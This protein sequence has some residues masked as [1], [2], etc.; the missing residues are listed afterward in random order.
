MNPEPDEA[1][2]RRILSGER[3]AFGK[4]YDRY[5]DSVYRYCLRLVADDATAQ[6]AMQNTFVKALESIATLDSPRAFRFWLFRIARNEVYAHF[7]RVKSN[8][9]VPIDQHAEEVWD[10]PTPLELTSSKELVLLVQWA[11]E[12]LKVEYREVLVL[13]E[14][15]QL[16]YQEIAAVMGDSESS[17]KSRIFK[18]RKALTTIL[19]PYMK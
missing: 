19:E 3:Q 9:Q 16:S 6:D 8:G 12:R 17:V 18:A 4:L 5:K 11:M 1:A 2:I 7:R 13:R 15:E 14:Y 10:A